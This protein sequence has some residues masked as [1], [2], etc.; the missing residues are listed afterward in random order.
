VRLAMSLTIKELTGLLSGEVLTA[1]HSLALLSLLRVATMLLAVMLLAVMLLAV[2]L[3][4]VS[5]YNLT[6]D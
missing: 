4:S 5:H 6:Q 3:A 2:M 1:L